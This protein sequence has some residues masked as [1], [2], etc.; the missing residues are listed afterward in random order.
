MAAQDAGAAPSGRP[1]QH[2]LAFPAELVVAFALVLSVL[3]LPNFT[4]AVGLASQ[5]S[6][7]EDFGEYITLATPGLA[8]YGPAIALVVTGLIA[9]GVGASRRTSAAQARGMTVLVFAVP[10]VSIALSGVWDTVLFAV[11]AALLGLLA[12][13]SRKNS[14]EANALALVFWVAIVGGVYWGAVLFAQAA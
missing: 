2:P 1:A 10:G 14:V 3:V 9:F 5:L 6:A 7:V 11:P 13:H 4:D 8:K 12:T